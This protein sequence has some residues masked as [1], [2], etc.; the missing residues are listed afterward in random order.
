M[1]D[2]G[3][4]PAAV[5]SRTIHFCKDGDPICAPPTFEVAVFGIDSAISKMSIHTGYQSVELNALGASA[6]NS[7]SVPVL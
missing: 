5:T 2:A 4:L 6:A 7:S 1:P 3:P